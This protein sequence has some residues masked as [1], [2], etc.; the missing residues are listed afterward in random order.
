M[1]LGKN[2][3]MREKL[4]QNMKANNKIS[5][6]LGEYNNTLDNFCFAQI[7]QLIGFG[8]SIQTLLTLLTF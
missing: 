4:D 2:N 7:P 5:L 6:T 3:I 8:F 1:N